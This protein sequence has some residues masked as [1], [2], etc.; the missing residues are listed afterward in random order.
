M[1]LQHLL[2]LQDILL[3]IE[4]QVIGR[5]SYN[6][7]ENILLKVLL[8]EMVLQDLT[9]MLDGE[10]YAVGGSWIISEENFLK[11]TTLLLV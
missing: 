4:F 10:F 1:E 9:Q 3:K 2:V 8:E 7:K 5:L 6:F 11:D